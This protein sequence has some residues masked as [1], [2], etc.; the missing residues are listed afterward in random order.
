MTK[1]PFK[2]P[3]LMVGRYMQLAFL[4]PACVFVGYGIGYYLDKLFGTS[5]LYL[6]FLLLGIAAGFVEM[7]RELLREP[8]D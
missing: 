6:V 2:S 7:I 4:L 3:L 8:R 5:F 1:P